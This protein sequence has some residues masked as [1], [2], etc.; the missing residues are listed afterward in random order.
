MDHRIQHVPKH[1]LLP[2]V[3]GRTQAKSS[4]QPFREVLNQAQTSQLKISKHAQHRL[5]ER[6]IT[7][8]EDKWKEIAFQVNEAK[9]KGITDSLVVTNDATLLVSAT[10]QT[11]VTAMDRQ[12]AQ[13]R[14]FTNINGTII[15]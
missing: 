12:E 4:T 5:N 15:L 8:S 14:I 6:N 1:A 11:V 3:T 2:A 9:Q 7:I 10:N 13:S